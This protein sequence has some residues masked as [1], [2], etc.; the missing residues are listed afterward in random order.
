MLQDLDY[1]SLEIISA[2]K[3]INVLNDEKSILITITFVNE[4][5][6]YKHLCG[7]EEMLHKLNLEEKGKYIK[8]QS[9][10]TQNSS[11]SVDINKTIKVIFNDPNQKYSTKSFNSTQV[12]D[13]ILMDVKF[14]EM[15]FDRCSTELKKVY[16]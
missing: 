14:I 8:L 13:E 15:F 5:D 3:N 11:N 4:K 2:V 7:I 9:S 1:N 10:Y 6:S 12:T 16:M